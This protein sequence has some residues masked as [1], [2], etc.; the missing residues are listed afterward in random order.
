MQNRKLVSGTGLV[1]GFALLGCPQPAKDAKDSKAQSQQSGSAD[2][3]QK[4]EGA[5]PTG[6]GNSG[7]GW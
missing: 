3:E 6:G 7:G 5:K 2:A 4:S 1:I